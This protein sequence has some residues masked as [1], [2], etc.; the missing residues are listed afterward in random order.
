V[1][2]RLNK[3]ALPFAAVLVL[4][5][6][7][8]AAQ[9][10]DPFVRG[11]VGIEVA[12]APL[13]ETWNL[14]GHREPALEG[15]VSFWGAVSSG[16]ALG[17]EF[18]NMYVWQH[19]TNAFVQGISPLV[20]IRLNDNPAWDWYFEGGPG[21]SWS[22]VTAPPHGTKFNYL[23]QFGTGVLRR[24]GDNHHLVLAYRF[25]HLS[26]NGREGKIRNPDFEMMGAYVGWA[27][28]F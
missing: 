4:V 28:S 22:D 20:R 24:T 3:P 10:R 1:N 6:A 27:L 16:V 7:S 5:A 19:P 13:V 21:V 17:V 12:A 18:H 2:A 9:A 14:N 11:T 26:N 23:F 8:A 25:L 15:S